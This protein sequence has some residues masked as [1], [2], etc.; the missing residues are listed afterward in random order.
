MSGFSAAIVA[1]VLSRWPAPAWMLY[2]TTRMAV[3][4]VARSVAQAAASEQ[5][6]ARGRDHL[7]RRHV[8]REGR[9][10]R[11]DS[12]DVAIELRG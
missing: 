7:L 5:P 11:R 12:S 9:K 8:P 1:I 2:E 6:R 3:G 4:F 10:E